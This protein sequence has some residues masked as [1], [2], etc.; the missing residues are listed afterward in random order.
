MRNCPRDI[1]TNF[2]INAALLRGDPVSRTLNLFY[3]IYYNWGS[4][5]SPVVTDER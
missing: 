4:L 3:G 2:Q 1:F 5:R